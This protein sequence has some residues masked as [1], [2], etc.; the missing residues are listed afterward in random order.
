MVNFEELFGKREERKDTIKPL[1]DQMNQLSEKQDYEKAKDV[2]DKIK[3]ELK[4]PSTGVWPYT[5]IHI[6]DIQTVKDVHDLVTSNSIRLKPDNYKFAD[7]LGLL[8]NVHDRKG[9]IQGAGY[10]D[11]DKQRKVV[12]EEMVCLG[13]AI[14]ESKGG[15]IGKSGKP[16]RAFLDIAHKVNPFLACKELE[17]REK[18]NMWKAIESG[19]KEEIERAR[20]RLK[21]YVPK[22]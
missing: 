14:P 12:A 19:K 5:Y 9:E 16:N 4:K 7:F 18:V 15:G 20:M 13:I 2:L 1:I 11:T 8:V 22:I 3:E 17:R 10:S 6:G 21:R